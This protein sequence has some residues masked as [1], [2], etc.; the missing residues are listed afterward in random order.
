MSRS[1]PPGRD[2]RDQL[3]RRDC[4]TL[5]H[6]FEADYFSPAGRLVP[7]TVESTD[8][9]RAAEL[10]ALRGLRAYDAVQLAGALKVSAYDATC[11]TFAT[12]DVELRR[13]AEQEGFD[14]LPTA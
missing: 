4:L 9:D 13:A 2:P 1:R 11:R 12:F 3:E 5:I 8:F 10:V 14:S 7:V 6:A